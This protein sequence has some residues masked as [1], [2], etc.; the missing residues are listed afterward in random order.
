MQVNLTFHARYILLVHVSKRCKKKQKVRV[1]FQSPFCRLMLLYLCGEHIRYLQLSPLRP[2]LPFLCSTCYIARS[3]HMSSLGA[4][5]TSPDTHSAL[6][7]Q[8]TVSQPELFTGMESENM[9]KRKKKKRAAG[10][11]RL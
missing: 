6:R 3:K 5:L 7:I 8:M 10:C 1:F 11:Q 2:S 9:K 4:S